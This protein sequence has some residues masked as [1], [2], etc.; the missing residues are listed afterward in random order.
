MTQ[1]PLDWSAII[2]AVA[3]SGGL[4]SLITVLA[5][6]K[7]ENAET[8]LVRA[9]LDIS[10]NKASLDIIDS[11]RKEVERFREDLESMREENKKLMI[12]NLAK[13]DRIRT[14]ESDLCIVKAHMESCELTIGVSPVIDTKI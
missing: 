9:Q 12:D 10:L 14:L 4:G 7:K 5:G 1:T 11:Y 8:D 3:A 6:R 2:A 13:N